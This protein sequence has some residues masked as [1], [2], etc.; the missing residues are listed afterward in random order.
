MASKDHIIADLRR[1]VD[2]LTQEV[3]DLKLQLAKANK[4]S[5]NSSKSPSSDITGAGKNRKKNK[6]G[7]PK[8]RTA[9]GQP[10]RRR[11]LRDRLP[12]DRVDEVIEYEIRENDVQELGLIPTDRYSRKEFKNVF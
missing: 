11:K 5:S 12:A 4:D 6:P 3:A 9:G 8:K 7:R 2:E 1:L 10:G